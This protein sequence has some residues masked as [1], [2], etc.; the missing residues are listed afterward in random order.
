[1]VGVL[2]PWI[3]IPARYLE[4]LSREELLQVLIHEGAHALRRDPLV[5]L[6]QRIGGA[7]FWWHPL[8]HLVNRDLTRAREEVCDNFVLTHTEPETYG[9]T[10][11]RLAT[12]SPAMARLPLAIGIFDSRGKLEERIRGLL[13]A[14]RKIMTRV[15]FLTAAT[16]LIA[17][18]LIS[19]VVAAT[20]VVAQNPAATPPDAPAVA[21]RDAGTARERRSMQRSLA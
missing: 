16:M 15:H 10:L 4:T 8:V 18:A 2:Q 3:L 11:L 1:M 21:E 19:V 14:R 12:L 17:F 20:R 5:A 6:L 9:A 7:L 13:D